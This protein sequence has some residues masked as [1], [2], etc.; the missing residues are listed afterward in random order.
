MFKITLQKK[1][2][3][4]QRNSAVY[5]SK[6]VSGRI[7]KTCNICMATINKGDVST[8]HMRKEN[9]TTEI[10]SSR[11]KYITYHTC[12]DECTKVFLNRR[13]TQ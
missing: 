5:G 12:N 10:P 1:E 3:F 8:T 11:K 13:F 2:I 4:E 6:V 9:R 7:K